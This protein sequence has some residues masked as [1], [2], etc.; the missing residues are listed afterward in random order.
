MDK[1]V[2]TIVF[3]GG[4]FWCTEAIFENLKGVI[5]VESG[6]AGGDLENPDYEQV[7]TGKTGHAEVIQIKYDNNIISLKAL[8]EVFF[9]THDPTTLNQ[10]E[11]DIGPQYRS[12]ILYNND[13]Q[14]IEIE[15]FIAKLTQDKI[16]K[17]E[18]VTETKS[19]QKFYSAEEYH[20]EYYKNNSNKPY[21]LL[22]INPKLRKFKKKFK[23]LIK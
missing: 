22:V 17:N 1:N 2:E 19:L 12:I 23:Q 11:N 20:Q 21:C 6:Y 10:Q 16:F 14:K 8:L 13:Q 5:S 3:G 9:S 15:D 7:K 4:C 18:I